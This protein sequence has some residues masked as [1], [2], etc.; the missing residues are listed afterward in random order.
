VTAIDPTPLVCPQ[1]GATNTAIGGSG[2]GM[3]FECA[4]TWDPAEVVALPRPALAP[5]GMAPTDEVYGAPQ[6]VVADRLAGTVEPESDSGTGSIGDDA[7]P[8]PHD[9]LPSWEGLRLFREAGGIIRDEVWWSDIM[10]GPPDQLDPRADE[11]DEPPVEVSAVMLLA[12]EIIAAG[13]TAY[14]TMNTPG[15]T[16]VA[17]TGYLP[18]DPDML[19]LV[20]QA[21]AVAVGMILDKTDE[22]AA[23]WA[24]RFGITLD[25]AIQG[26]QTTEVGNDEGRSEAE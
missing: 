25:S 12:S 19:P 7:P 5:F 22:P 15:S 11:P 23:V 9:Y 14:H 1:C 3:C 20:E 26:D 8:D 2:N 6:E 18:D 10:G 16:L 24:D 13:I 17:E 4:H 21:C